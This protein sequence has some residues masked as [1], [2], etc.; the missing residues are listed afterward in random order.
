MPHRA[1]RKILVR[2]TVCIARFQ[3]VIAAVRGTKEHVKRFNQNR[4][5]VMCISMLLIA[6]AR[7]GLA[8]NEED[9]NLESI[10]KV[11]D[12]DGNIYSTIRIGTQVWMVENL[13]T[14]KYR[15]GT[16]IIRVE[17]NDRWSVIASG[18]YCRPAPQSSVKIERYGLLYNF[19][20]V[21]DCSGLC[22]DGWR[23]P[24]ADEWRE[25]IDFLG[26]VEVA[27]GKMKTSNTGIWS[28][29]VPGTTNESG[30][31]ALPAGGRGRLG[32]A[33][34]VGNYATWWSST[35]HDS[36]YAWHWGLHPDKHNIRA[37]PGHI[38]S[39]FSVRCI[40]DEKG[41]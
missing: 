28:V 2:V 40:K 35:T 41:P 8:N 18:A 21:S 34:E 25:L 38:Q 26:G 3:Q 33:G 27:G 31:S 36:L 9:S 20:A 13:A 5:L 1:M 14:T 15:D 17:D 39:G 4:Y 11:K 7:L 19:H 6:S 32:S 23:V 30:F 12:I 29:Q 24:T 10:A 37:N 16:S 22:P